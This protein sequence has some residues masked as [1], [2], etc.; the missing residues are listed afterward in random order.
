[1]IKVGTEEVMKLKNTKSE[2]SK[3]LFFSLYTVVV[4]RRKQNV[5]GERK[6][7]KEGN[8]TKGK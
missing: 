5:I 7:I 8:R 4:G 6:R 2:S 1:M 3:I